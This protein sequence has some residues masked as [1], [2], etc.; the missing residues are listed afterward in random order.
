MKHTKSRIIT[1]VGLRPGLLEKAAALAM[2]FHAWLRASGYQAAFV[3]E[4]QGGDAHDLEDPSKLT[5]VVSGQTPAAG[6][7]VW[8]L[9]F[10]EARDTALAERIYMRTGAC[11]A[12]VDIDETFPFLDNLRERAERVWE[13]TLLVEVPKFSPSELAAAVSRNEYLNIQPALSQ[14]ASFFGFTEKAMAS[15][16]EVER[17]K[18][19]VSHREYFKQRIDLLQTAKLLGFPLL[20]MYRHLS[21]RKGN[22]DLL[23][24]FADKTAEEVNQWIEQ[25]LSESEVTTGQRRYFAVTLLILLDDY[26]KK[27]GGGLPLYRS[28]DNIIAR[29]DELLS[30]LSQ[31]NRLLEAEELL[32]VDDIDAWYKLAPLLRDASANADH[33]EANVIDM[34]AFRVAALVAQDKSDRKRYLDLLKQTGESLPLGTREALG[35]R[36]FFAVHSVQ[37]KM[38]DLL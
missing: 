32:G 28:I 1:F 31:L 33:G 24:L 5:V 4:R 34:C 18:K 8:T 36:S 12:I 26:R 6:P 16:T 27:K 17:Q 21:M 2:A 20:S 10:A 9:T 7:I 35:L 3:D 30:S 14:L 11:C 38:R 13:R 23:A 29:T 25:Q 15:G 37:V 22:E 19:Q